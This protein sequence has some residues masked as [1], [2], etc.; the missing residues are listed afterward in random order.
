MDSS[1]ENTN[2]FK[3]L[4]DNAE[5]YGF[6]LR[7]PKQKEDITQ[8]T[9]EP[10]HWRYVGEENAKKMNELGLCLEEYVE[11]LNN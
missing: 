7:Y 3:W 2:A 11:Y 8:V 6:V 4:K 9:Y 1:F 10:W 5:N